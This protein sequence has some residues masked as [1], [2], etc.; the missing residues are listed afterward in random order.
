MNIITLIAESLAEM[1]WVGFWIWLFV[2]LWRLM[3]AGFTAPSHPRHSCC[4]IRGL[5][6]LLPWALASAY[7]RATGRC[8]PA[9]LPWASTVLLMTGIAVA[10]VI[11]KPCLAC[12]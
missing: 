5:V 8:P 11:I 7:A 6:D 9:W 1:F 3:F 4:D 2:F 12:P 10:C